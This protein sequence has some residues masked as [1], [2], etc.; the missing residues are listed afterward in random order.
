LKRVPTDATFDQ[1]HGLK[2]F[3]SK[4]R[5]GERVFSYDL[6]AATDRLPIKLQILILNSVFNNKMGDL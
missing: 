2:V 6:S 4:M 5:P 3:F 1:N